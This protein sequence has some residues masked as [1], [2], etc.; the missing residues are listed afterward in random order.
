M[1]IQTEISLTGWI[2]VI[3]YR[4]NCNNFGDHDK[5]LIVQYFGLCLNTWKVNVIPIS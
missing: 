2:F 3:F 5:I 1:L 4:K